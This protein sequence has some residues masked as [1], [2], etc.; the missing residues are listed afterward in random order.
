M[1]PGSGTVV[2]ETGVAVTTA[3]PP[4]AIYALNAPCGLPSM[5][6]VKREFEPVGSVVANSGS[7]V[8]GLRS[9]NEK[10]SGKELKFGPFVVTSR[11]NEN[12]LP[13]VIPVRYSLKNDDGESIRVTVPGSV[14]VTSPVVETAPRV[15]SVERPEMVTVLEADPPFNKSKAR[16]AEVPDKLEV[17]MTTE[18]VESANSLAGVMKRVRQD[19]TRKTNFSD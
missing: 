11:T 16:S 17:A 15:P 8:T 1:V 9:N 12:L 7:P 13:R 14:P 18:Y 5:F 6:S 2:V 19:K 3:S 4:G 10:A